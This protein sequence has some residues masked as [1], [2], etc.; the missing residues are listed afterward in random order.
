MA[1]HKAATEKV[2][3]QAKMQKPAAE[4]HAGFS[5][6][7]GDRWARVAKLCA[8]ASDRPLAS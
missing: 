3:L 8:L 6:A 4:R 1:I 5:V 7:M 2:A